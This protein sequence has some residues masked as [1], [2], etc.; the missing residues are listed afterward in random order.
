MPVTV[1]PFVEFEGNILIWIQNNIRTPALDVFMKGLTYFAKAGIVWIVLALILIAM[2][3]TRRVGV[4]AGIA[5]LVTFIIVNGILKPCV[6]RIRPYV[7][8]E[9]L[10]PL[11]T[12]SDKCFPSGHASNAFACAWVMFRKMKGRYGVPALLMA[13]LISLS[14]L[15]VGVH[16]PT[17]VLCGALVG[18]VVAELTVRIAPPYVK[19]MLKKLDKKSGKTIKKKSR[20]KAR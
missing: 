4:Y 5:I 11:T 3:K 15:Y 17:D 2:K 16:Y 19:K 7:T 9:D 8:F 10:I 20:T 12:E 13:I 6:G 1:S 18:F 14:R